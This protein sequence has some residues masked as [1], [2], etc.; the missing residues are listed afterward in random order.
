MVVRLTVSD[1]TTAVDDEVL[2]LVQPEGTEGVNHP[3]VA[4][5]GESRA[6]GVGSAVVLDATASTDPDGDALA[7]A[8]SQ[9]RRRARRAG[10]RRRPPARASPQPQ[11][12]ALTFRVEVTDGRGGVDLADVTIT[13]DPD[14][15]SDR[16]DEA[17]RGGR[18]LRLHEHQ[19]RNDGGA[20]LGVLLLLGLLVPRRR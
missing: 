17:P 18:G 10:R 5:A 7:F 3:P 6:V 20:I 4:N 1:G 14:H 12:G 2:V 8:W 19:L 9:H 11:P 16:R 15:R 13:V